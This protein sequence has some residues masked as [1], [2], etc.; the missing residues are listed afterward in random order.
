MK[1]DADRCNK[2]EVHVEKTIVG[3]NVLED[4]EERVLEKRC[5]K[6]SSFCCV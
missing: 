5:R 4:K 6:G 2:K 1:L 3:L